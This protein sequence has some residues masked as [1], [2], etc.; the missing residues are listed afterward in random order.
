MKLFVQQGDYAVADDWRS[1]DEG[2]DK[3]HHV[4]TVSEL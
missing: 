2:K 3:K 1:V 4:S